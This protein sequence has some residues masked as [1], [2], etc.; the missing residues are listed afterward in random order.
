MK[1]LPSVAVIIAVRN[2]GGEKGR[3]DRSGVL[4]RVQAAAAGAQLAAWDPSTAI[5]LFS[6]DG[7]PEAS[8][9]PEWVAGVALGSRVDTPNNVLHCCAGSVL[10]GPYYNIYYLCVP[11][12]RRR[13]PA[14]AITLVRTPSRRYE[15]YF[16]QLARNKHGPM[17]PLSQTRAR[18]A[19]SRI[20]H[21]NRSV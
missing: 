17:P 14:S 4:D 13:T 5:K 1:S 18:M 15:C 20:L 19:F 2:G 7:S 16:I 6:E 11:A 12:E 21:D 10:S 9:C 3:R 8:G